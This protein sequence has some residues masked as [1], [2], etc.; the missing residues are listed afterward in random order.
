MHVHF[1]GEP[2]DGITVSSHHARALAERGVEVSIDGSETASSPKPDVIHLVTYGQRNYRLLRS[3]VAARLAGVPLLRYWT[4]RD[5]LW[6]KVHSASRAF[7]HA[8]VRLGAV[9]LARTQALVDDLARIGVPASPGPMLSLHVF[10]T[11]QPEPLPGV[12]TVL[13]HLPTERRDF[14]GGRWVDTLIRRMPSVRFLILGDAATDYGAFRNVE[15]LGVVDDVSRAIQRSTVTIVPRLDGVLSRLA[16]ETLCQGRHAVTT[17]PAPH[18]GYAESIEGFVRTIR[19]FERD[20][21]FNLD[22]RE[23]VC[24]EYGKPQATRQL[25]QALEGCLERGQLGLQL[26]GGWRGAMMALCNPG[27]FGR[28]SFALPDPDSLPEEATAFHALLAAE[29]ENRVPVPAY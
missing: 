27:I 29:V 2:D 14:C 9:Q 10:N 20:V 1:V 8:V 15:S 21:D 25:F 26:K 28:K 24:R 7:A 13:C 17:C 5:V 6:A 18:C 22:G 4:G 19:T 12:F 3:L 16:L 23:Y 11:Y